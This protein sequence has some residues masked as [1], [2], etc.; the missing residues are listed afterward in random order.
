MRI[1]PHLLAV[2]TH[3]EVRRCE[4]LACHAQTSRYGLC[5]ALETRLVDQAGAEDWLAS[6]AAQF[7]EKGVGLRGCERTRA[8]IEAVAA[9]Q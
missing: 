7:S 2:I 1:C 8:I 3:A 6:V 4:R 9:T 5:G